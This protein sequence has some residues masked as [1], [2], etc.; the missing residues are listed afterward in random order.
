[1][2]ELKYRVL[3]TWGTIV[4]HGIPGHSSSFVKEGGCVGFR[5]KPMDFDTFEEAEREGIKHT[6][7]S[8]Y[9]I[10]AVRSPESKGEEPP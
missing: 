2:I 6:P 3:L 8:S 4:G 5:G 1:M 10:V 7:G 9:D